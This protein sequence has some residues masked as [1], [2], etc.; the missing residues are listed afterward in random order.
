MARDYDSQLLE[1]VAV[2]RRRMRDALLFGAQRGRRTLDER[3]GKVFA[4]IAITAVLCAGCVGWSF[5]QATLAKQKAEQ[6]KQQ[7][8]QEQLFNPSPTASP[9]DGP[10]ATSETR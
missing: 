6:K 8:Q 7:Q 1:S 3:L 10:S 9:T 2:R 4:G 5:L